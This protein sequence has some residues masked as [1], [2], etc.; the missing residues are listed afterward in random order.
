M[1]IVFPNSEIW[2]EG[3]IAELILDNAL[4][5]GSVLPIVMT[6]L[7]RMKSQKSG[8]QSGSVRNTSVTPP[9]EPPP[10]LVFNSTIP[11]RR[12]R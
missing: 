5:L 9:A 7:T 11:H 12:L 4:E 6:S 2:Q 1:S 3:F 8:N 10:G